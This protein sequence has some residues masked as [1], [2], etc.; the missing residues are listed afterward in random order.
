M[1]L[2][3]PGSAPPPPPLPLPGLVWEVEKVAE[4]RPLCSGCKDTPCLHQSFEH[5][6]SGS[7]NGEPLFFCRVSDASPLFFRCSC[8]QWNICLPVLQRLRWSGLGGF[9]LLDYFPSKP[10]TARATG[11]L[12]EVVPEEQGGR[13]RAPG[14]T[15][16]ASRVPSAG[17]PRPH[18]RGG[19]T[20]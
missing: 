18:L 14:R 17:W 2:L 19:G 20:L 10:E 9:V 8:Q 3:K 5:S 15:F 11:Y 12:S 4:G 7:M 1:P 13:W 6:A 16:R